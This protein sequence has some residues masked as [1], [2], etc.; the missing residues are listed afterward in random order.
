M[1][2]LECFLIIKTYY[3]FWPGYF[4]WIAVFKIKFLE[5]LGQ[6]HL[7]DIQLNMIFYKSDN[8]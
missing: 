3:S 2:I 5:L 7:K 4:T 8:S 6:K 1:H